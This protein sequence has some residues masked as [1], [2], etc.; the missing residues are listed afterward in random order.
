MS[1]GS[2]VNEGYF[3]W[4]VNIVCRDIFNSSISYRKLMVYLHSTRFTYS[5]PKDRNR[6]EDGKDLRWRYSLLCNDRSIQD[7]LR[8]PCSVLEMLIALAV[9]CEEDIMS[10]PRM[11]DRTSQW[12]W[13]MIVNLGLGG[14]TDDVFDRQYVEEC[15]DIFLNRKYDFDGKGGLFTVKHPNKDMRDVE[16]WYQ[17]CWYLDE[18][19]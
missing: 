7:A 4:M 16:I 14:M 18:Y 15:I 12:F 9:K 10:D 5:I 3:E 13:R 11:G 8:G 1:F 6:A 2:D 19:D 17:L